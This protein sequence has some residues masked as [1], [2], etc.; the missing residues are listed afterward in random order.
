MRRVPQLQ[1]L[2]KGVDMA[3]RQALLSKHLQLANGLLPP[4]EIQE[5]A[6]VDQRIAHNLE[7]LP[8]G[9]HVVGL[10]EWLQ[11]QQRKVTHCTPSYK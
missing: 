9:T 10:Y 11:Q 1:R 8:Q 3:D 6:Q 5:G 4:A 2:C 7:Q